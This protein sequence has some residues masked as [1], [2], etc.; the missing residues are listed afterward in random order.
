ME[1][2][3]AAI[4]RECA[5]VT[6]L[7]VLAD[8]VRSVVVSKD[9]SGYCS[10]DPAGA[11]LDPLAMDGERVRAAELQRQLGL[12]A[13]ED[14]SFNRLLAFLQKPIESVLPVGPRSY[15]DAGVHLMGWWAAYGDC[16][17]WLRERTTRGPVSKPRPKG[18]FGLTKKEAPCISI[19]SLRDAA[20]GSETDH[21][22]RW[23]CWCKDRWGDALSA[24]AVWHEL[25]FH[26]NGDWKSY[27]DVKVDFFDA[28]TRAAAFGWVGAGALGAGYPSAR[29]RSLPYPDFHEAAQKLGLA[30][31]ESSNERG[32]SV[33]LRPL[34]SPKGIRLGG[35]AIRR[36]KI[37]GG[38]RLTDI[39]VQPRPLALLDSVAQD[40]EYSSLMRKM[41]TQGLRSWPA[42]LDIGN[43]L[44]SSLSDSSVTQRLCEALSVVG[45]MALLGSESLVGKYAANYPDAR[46]YPDAKASQALFSLDGF[47]V[48]TRRDSEPDLRVVPWRGEVPEAGRIVLVIGESQLTVGIGR[49]DRVSLCR[50]SLFEHILAYDC[51]AWS[52]ST[53]SALRS[54]SQGNPLVE[55]ASALRRAGGWGSDWEALKQDLL[56]TPAVGEV[57]QLVSLFIR[58]RAIALDWNAHASVITAND[59]VQSLVSGITNRIATLQAEVLSAIS[60]GDGGALSRLSPPRITQGNQVGEIDLERWLREDWK[61]VG[62]G[63]STPYQVAVAA[64]PGFRIKERLR[65]SPQIYEIQ[66]PAI[67]DRERELLSLPG[68]ICWSESFQPPEYVCLFHRVV[69]SEVLAASNG[70]PLSVDMVAAAIND[71]FETGAEDA[72][73]GLVKATLSPIGR[74]QRC[75]ADRYMAFMRSDGRFGSQCFPRVDLE[76]DG[77][78]VLEPAK[79]SDTWLTFAFSDSVLAKSDVS[80]RFS[81]SPDR[82]CR[83]ISRGP[84]PVAGSERECGEQA[85]AGLICSH[86]SECTGQLKEWG[87]AIQASSDRHVMFGETLEEGGRSAAEILSAVANRSV[88]SVVTI[89][90]AIA[91]TVFRCVRGWLT[92]VGGNVWPEVWA[93]AEGSPGPTAFPPDVSSNLGVSF[94]RH[95]PKGSLIVN[96]FR[97]QMPEFSRAFEGKWSAGWPAGYD[98]IDAFVNSCSSDS[99]KWKEFILRLN[100]LPS[101][102]MEGTE[103][104]NAILSALHQHLSGSDAAENGV[105]GLAWESLNAA[106]EVM[107][108][109]GFCVD[110][111]PSESVVTLYESGYRPTDFVRIGDEELVSGQVRIVKRGLRRSSGV[112]YKPRASAGHEE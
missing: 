110:I 26:G 25:L 37:A 94:S 28:V 8:V 88:D 19:T 83:T 62:V 45:G 96:G 6:R 53:V 70:D 52:I 73:D 51:H 109:M 21:P 84:L 91:D 38:R 97:I 105:D 89:S 63:H 27:E 34:L 92:A 80:I 31:D 106:F 32:P 17:V 12:A 33:V 50:P 68:A 108:K 69:S 54:E 41:A 42:R 67:S 77:T 10:G 66:I 22:I 65:E 20:I 3:K 46:S 99:T 11:W 61:R 78:W 87:E 85:W 82:A 95:V 101:A 81:P 103:R 107:L 49:V 13:K 58:V 5:I 74:D 40:S 23:Y 1:D 9:E 71:A 93:A 79:A 76:I 59:G 102:V 100:E 24:Q 47:G 60:V 56:A 7:C 4:E 18:V 39:L 15:P 55:I 112:I 98:A 2:I 57:E 75:I 86:L 90:D 36:T 29:C 14:A 35:A 72:F 48:K 111:F 43:W 104:E 44:V 64:S 16:E 30:L